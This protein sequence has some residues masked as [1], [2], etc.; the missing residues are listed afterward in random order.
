MH[1]ALI[2]GNIATKSVREVLFSVFQWFGMPF[3][4]KGSGKETV[5][6]PY[7]AKMEGQQANL[8]GSAELVSSINLPITMQ[9]LYKCRP[10]RCP[11]LSSVLWI[12]LTAV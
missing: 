6:K 8:I 11:Q 9:E 4:V 10:A 12:T 7:A 5:A 2:S 1:L 3:L